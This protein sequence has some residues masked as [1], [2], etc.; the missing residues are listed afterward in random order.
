MVLIKFGISIFL[1]VYAT[2]HIFQ[3][4][5]YDYKEFENND[6]GYIP[7]WNVFIYARILIGAFIVFLGIL[8]MRMTI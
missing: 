8:F 1:F 2:L 5:T 4:A 3:T 7:N 6:K